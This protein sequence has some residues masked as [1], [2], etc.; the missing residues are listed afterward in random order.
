MPKS[1]QQPANQTQPQPSKSQAVKL[2]I[3][4][5]TISNAQVAV[6]SDIPGVK[7]MDITLPTMD[8]K[9][10]GNADGTDSG[11]AIKDVAIAVITQMVDGA[12][13]SGKLPSSLSGLM[14]GDLTGTAQKELDKLKVPVNVGGLLNSLGGKK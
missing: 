7:P 12:T 9:N 4:T 6:E 5:L 1:T 8:M 3:D 2:V 14:S 10:I 13:K 11:A